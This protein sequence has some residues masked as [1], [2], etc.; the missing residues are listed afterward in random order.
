M[1][2]NVEFESSQIIETF[3]HAWRTTGVQRLGYLYGRYEKHLDVPLG[4]KAVVACIYEPPQKGGLLPF[5]SLF[6]Y[7]SGQQF[8]F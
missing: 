1:V 5:L 7:L 4:I 6:D 8:L 3:L 2:D